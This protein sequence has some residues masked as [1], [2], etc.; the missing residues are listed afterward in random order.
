MTR[1]PVCGMQMEEKDAA[2]KTDYKGRTYYFCSA[3]CKA[4]FEKEPQRYAG[5]DTPRKSPHSR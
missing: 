2:G 1:D 3:D 5:E 4:A